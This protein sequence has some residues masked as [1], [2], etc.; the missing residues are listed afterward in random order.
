MKKLFITL[1]SI[2]IM[3]SA[4]ASDEVFN[5]KVSTDAIEIA[6]FRDVVCKFEQ[7][8]T[9][10]SSNAIIKSGGDFKFVLKKGVIF[11]TLYP[12]K[13]TT[14]YT[15][16][17][18]KYVNDIIVGISKKNFSQIEKTFDI[19]YMKQNEKWVLGLIPKVDSPAAL[20]L[21]NIIIFGQK[22]I[23]RIYINTINNGST[24]LKFSDCQ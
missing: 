21:K 13:Y 9:I 3:S 1:L 14:S 11:E 6:P 4:N 12:V 17:E 10:P 19:H 16:K 23:D 20:Q 7:E 8:K 18:N 5:H 22:D 2:L 15:S 24:K